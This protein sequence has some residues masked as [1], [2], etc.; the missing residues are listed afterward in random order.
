MPNILDELS[1]ML[2]SDDTNIDDLSL[3]PA[4]E[5]AIFIATIMESMGPE[6]TLSFVSDH[7]DELYAYGLI[8]NPEAA[9]EATKNIV[10]LNKQANLD[11][12]T[13]LCAIRLARKANDAGYKL[14][15]KGRDMML[16]GREQIMTKF[17]NKAKMEAKKNINN[18]KRKA[19]N[20]GTKQGADIAKRMDQQMKKFDDKGKNEAIAK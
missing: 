12:E 10:R 6:E 1:A 15:R 16:K 2:N 8:D 5:S 19:A 20:M 18:A 11:R 9:V 13:T 7:A 17:G 14:Y 4:E 3:D